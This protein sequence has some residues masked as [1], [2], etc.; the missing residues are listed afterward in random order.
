MQLEKTVTWKDTCTP[1]F[2]AALFIIARTRKQ[3]DR[4]LSCRTCRRLMMV[5]RPWRLCGG[6]MVA[7]LCGGGCVLC[8]LGY[9]SLFSFCPLEWV[10]SWLRAGGKMIWGLTCPFLPL[11]FFTVLCWFHGYNRVTQ[12]HIYICIY[13]KFCFSF[14]YSF[15][16]CLL[17]DTEYSSQC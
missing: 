14:S 11:S 13:I 4:S 5:W 15:S 17:Q 2:I 9:C 12:L 8:L 6:T 7:A 16:L 1:V 3:P 10:H